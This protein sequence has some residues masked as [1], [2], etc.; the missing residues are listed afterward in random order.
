M[1]PKS[2]WGCREA[3]AHSA[4]E[5]I[6][7]PGVCWR[8]FYMQIVLIQLYSEHFPIIFLLLSLLWIPILKP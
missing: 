6:S 4:G 2:T 3:K 8:D 5:R 1:K 7:W